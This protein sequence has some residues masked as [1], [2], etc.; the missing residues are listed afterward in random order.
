[1]AGKIKNRQNSACLILQLTRKYRYVRHPR[2]LSR[3]VRSSRNKWIRNRSNN[4]DYDRSKSVDDDDDGGHCDYA[5]ED[6]ED[7][8]DEPDDLSE[9]VLDSTL[10]VV[11][12]PSECDVDLLLSDEDAQWHL[13]N[14]CGELN[15]SDGGS[16]SIRSTRLDDEDS[17]SHLIALMQ[18]SSTIC[19]R[20]DARSKGSI[21]LSHDASI[22]DAGATD[23]VI[24]AVHHNMAHSKREAKK[25]L[26]AKHSES[27]YRL[28]HEEPIA[29]DWLTKP[30]ALYEQTLVEHVLTRLRESLNE[31]KYLQVLETLAVEEDNAEDNRED[32]ETEDDGLRA[33]DSAVARL[34]QRLQTIIH[35]SSELFDELVLC[36][37]VTEAFTLG[38][39]FDFFYWKKFEL[40]AHKLIRHFE[41][42]LVALNRLLKNLKQLRQNCDGELDKKRLRTLMNRYLNG[43]PYLIHEFSALFLDELPPDHLFN[44]PDSF[45]QLLLI[46][47]HHPHHHSHHLQHQ[48]QPSVN[49]QECSNQS[50][51]DHRSYESIEIKLNA[52]D[53][54]YGTDQCPCRLCH[55]SLRNLADPRDQEAAGDS[56]LAT[57]ATTNHCIACSLKFISGKPFA[58]QKN[59]KLQPVLVDFVASVGS[60]P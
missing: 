43:H 29:F 9:L 40:F 24:T 36:L 1:M 59:R 28:L 30:N 42:D 23:S 15:L 2:Q 55:H 51:R 50:D 58:I 17:E 60:S 12:Q 57:E 38:R 25:S 33:S 8:D 13:S 20:Q 18:A 32:N 49:K 41:P 48:T 21:H 53:Q 56:S 34:L 27:T 54:L 47:D 11:Q 44:D 19:V 35:D 4:L 22:T 10:P 6:D 14:D 46:T 31:E 52:T 26:L 37:N 45:D 39:H 3:H 16:T 7:D 5:T